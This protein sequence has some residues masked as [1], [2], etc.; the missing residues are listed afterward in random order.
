MVIGGET[1]GSLLHRFISPHPTERYKNVCCYIVKAQYHCLCTPI[2]CSMYTN[3]IN[4]PY[5]IK[6][7]Y[8]TSEFK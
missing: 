8:F 7:Y 3:G 5:L 2:I 4:K 6:P 1:R